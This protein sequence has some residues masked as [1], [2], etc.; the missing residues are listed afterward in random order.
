M[1]SGDAELDS[2]VFTSLP[3]SNAGVLTLDGVDIA[4]GDAAAMSAVSGLRFYPNTSPTVASTQFTFTPIFADGSAGEDVAVGLYL[5]T[6]QNNAPIAE[7]L[8]LVTYK[9]VALTGQFSAV[10]PEGDILTFRLVDKPARGAVT[11]SEDGSAQFVYTPY[12]NKTGKDSFTYVAVDAVGNTSEPATVKIKIDKADTKVTYADM[13]GVS[14]YRSALRLAEEGVLI[15]EQVGGLY[16][17]HPDEL[18]T[19]DQFV[20]LAMHTVGLDAL[21]G[22]TVTGLL[23]MRPFP[24]GL[25]AMSLLP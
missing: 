1:E 22:V 17:F 8:N 7:N 6:A 4:V 5:L 12:E 13:D 9:N 20:A 24:P 15:G 11:L 19:R 14:A 16:Y 10:D 21:E 23:T 18:V 25:R 3:D 2:I